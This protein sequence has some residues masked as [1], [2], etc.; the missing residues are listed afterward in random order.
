MNDRSDIE[1]VLG[2]WMEDGP[3]AMPD[4]VIDVVARRIRVRPQRRAW[5]LIR[6]SSMS[7]IARWGAAVAAV[8]VVA[9]VGYNLLPSQ[10]GIGGPASPNPTASPTAAAPLNSPAAS[11]PACD[12]GA[13]TCAGI[14]QA[15]AQTAGIFRPQ[16]AF[17]VPAGWTN[18]FQKNRTY[19]LHYNFARGHFLQVLSQNAIPAQNASCSAERK[20]GV[21]NAVEDWV[22]FLTT[23]PGLTAST[24]AAVSVGGYAGMQLD[25]HVSPGWTATC[26]NS[27]GP[28]VVLITDSGTVPDRAKWID[29]Q[30]A[31]FR[32][33]DV[34]GETVIIYLESSSNPADL[35]A[36]NVQFQPL[37]DS[38]AFSP[39]S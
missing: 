23:H 4:R 27:L 28:A 21:G 14:L 19:M 20:A 31:T 26:P 17:N 3:V 12:P 25:V 6:R 5:R 39:G 7:P 15:G 18:P 10:R 11:T 32:I 1:R 34:A 2:Y 13:T 35:A 30:N 33:L 24:P 8:L 29:D 38:F 37:F 9:V 36:L 16:L 22:A